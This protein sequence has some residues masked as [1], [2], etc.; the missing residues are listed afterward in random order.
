MAIN[1]TSFQS[2]D[3]YY[4]KI[5]NLENTSSFTVFKGKFYACVAAIH[6]L[7]RIVSLKNRRTAFPLGIFNKKVTSPII[8]GEIKI[9][10]KTDIYFKNFKI[11][12]HIKL[13]SLLKKYDFSDSEIKLLY[14]EFNMDYKIYADDII[15]IRIKAAILINILFKKSNLIL[16]HTAGLTYPSSMI[17]YQRIYRRLQEYPEKSAIVFEYREELKR[18]AFEEVSV[19]NINNYEE[20]IIR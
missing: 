18:I 17:I 13:Y 20:W 10:K 11:F 5:Y 6:N 9:E 1:H 3:N 2:S 7:G 12:K 8:I 4:L 19:D 15:H 16:F 14:E